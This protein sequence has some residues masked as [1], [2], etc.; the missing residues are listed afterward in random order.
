M[1]WIMSFFPSLVPGL[2]ALMNPWI[3]LALGGALVGAFLF[4][5][6]LGN[7][8]LEAFESAVAAEGNAALR[9]RQTQ[10]KVNKS[11]TE[12]RNHAHELEVQNLNV[13]VTALSE[14]LRNNA[15]RRYVPAVPST[16]KGGGAG[17]VCYSRETLNTGLQRS[18]GRLLERVAGIVATGDKARADFVTCAKWVIEQRD[19]ALL[20]N[21]TD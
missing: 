6:H 4:G 2:G 19:A 7:S 1:K 14:R 12:R 8:R 17:V 16:P 13:R 20:T 11:I 5:L 9:V 3:L 18:V 10:I 15:G 21:G